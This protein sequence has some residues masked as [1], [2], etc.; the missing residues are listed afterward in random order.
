MGTD[1]AGAKSK[2]NKVKNN[3]KMWDFNIENPQGKEEETINVDRERQ[4][5]QDVNTEYSTKFADKIAEVT[6]GLS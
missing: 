1:L 6:K 3:G 2:T 5:T 4:E